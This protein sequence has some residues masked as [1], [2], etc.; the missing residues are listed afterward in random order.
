MTE[1]A[2]HTRKRIPVTISLLLA[3]VAF[4]GLVSSILESPQ[5]EAEF[6]HAHLNPAVVESVAQWDQ[7]DFDLPERDKLKLE[8]IITQSER[9]K[10][11]SELQTVLIGQAFHSALKNSCSTKS[12]PCDIPLRLNRRLR[13]AEVNDDLRIANIEESS[14]R[15]DLET[16]F[17][18]S[19]VTLKGISRERR[20]LRFYQTQSGWV[21]N[22]SE[23][24]EAK[25]SSFTDRASNFSQM[26]NKRFTGLNYY[27]ASASWAEFWKVFPIE[28]IESDLHK[29]ST[30]NVNALRIFLNH[31]YFDK[32]ETREDGLAK[33]IKFLDICENKDIK[34]L[35]TLFDL[36]PN[37]TLSNWADD[38]QHIDS[39]LSTMNEH[40]AILG[41]DLKNQP[42]LDFEIWG[43]GL[44][45]AWLTVM[46]R[47]VQTQYPK[48]AVTTGWSKAENAV[49]LKDVFD[50]I[51]YHEYENPENFEDRLNSIITVIDDKPV[52][53]TELGS[54]VWH[55]PFI[56]RFG[57]SAQA[58]RLQSQLDQA[59]QTN[60]V[61]VWTLN[62]FDHVGKD[63]VGPLP[64]RQAQQRHFGLLRA[65][66]TFRPAADVL[67][68]FG[69]RSENA[70]A[71]PDLTNKSTF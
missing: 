26:F 17:E 43:K 31:D 50:I 8:R 61:F 47:H 52:M 9:S 38:I 58:A 56:R 71:E 51:T 15:V 24:V 21:Q 35:V 49:R 2:L 66:D 4:A 55:P 6:L 57:E 65:D 13:A 20:I 54:T 1:S 7:V 42:D 37:Y 69:K 48:L 41:V 59:A 53:I 32:S 29:A 39:V 16:K 68:S 30:L 23:V 46:A 22:T 25:H 19:D 40:N 12:V 64:W 27:P 34:V 10:T 60:G 3:G 44:V 62:D 36:R 45:E 5:T 28:D 11:I 18:A 14:L 33:L 63:V 70:R 67:K